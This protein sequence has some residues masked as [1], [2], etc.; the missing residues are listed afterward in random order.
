ME[1][2]VL[3]VW[4]WPHYACHLPRPPALPS[5][6]PPPPIRLTAVRSVYCCGVDCEGRTTHR[7]DE[8]RP[9]QQQQRPRQPPRRSEQRRGQLRQLWAVRLMH[10]Q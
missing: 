7:C 6:P 4:R 10:Q 8:K 9:V 3:Q 5:P 1:V 2:V